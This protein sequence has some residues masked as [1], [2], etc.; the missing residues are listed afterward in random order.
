MANVMF[1]RGSQA[2]LLQYINGTKQA[3]EGSFYLTS[4]TNRL[5]IGKT[6]T[7]DN[8][9][10]AVPVNQ[11]VITVAS[12]NNLPSRTAIEAG[13]FYY[14]SG[15]NILCIY[16]GAK[17]VQINPDTNTYI[18]SRSITSSTSSITEN[19]TTYEFA[20]V[21]DIIEDVIESGG[22]TQDNNK[23]TSKFAVDGRNGVNVSVSTF[24]DGTKTYPRLV[25]SQAEQVFTATAAGDGINATIKLSD[26]NKDTEF[27]L[28]GS[29]NVLISAGSSAN[30]IKI[31]AINSTMDSASGA[32]VTNAFDANGGFTTT[33]KDS[34]GQS[35]K[36][37]AITPKISYGPQEDGTTSASA[38]FKNGNAV[39]D[40]YTKGQIDSKLRGVN[41]MVYRGT[42]G[43]GGTVTIL[44]T[45]NVSIGDT[46]KVVSNNTIAHASA[47]EGFCRVGDVL[48]ATSKSNKEGA[49]G[50]I[51]SSDLVWDY[52][53][54]GDDSQIDTQYFT[55]AITNGSLLMQDDGSNGISK[56]GFSLETTDS[57]DA[58]STVTYLD[59]E[60]DSSIAANAKNV[61]NK[62]VIKHKEQAG[63]TA[64][65]TTHANALDATQTY[66]PDETEYFEIEVPVLGYD[67]AGHITSV[68]S[69]TY[70]LLDTHQTYELQYLKSTTAT[71]TYSD[72]NAAKKGT[73]DAK[74]TIEVALKDMNSGD[75]VKK[76][77]MVTSE[78][79]FLSSNGTNLS[80]DIEWGTF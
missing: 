23:F 78:T 40:V 44:P 2:D 71:S 6:D 48:I 77:F 16:N 54:S 57:S 30:K 69:K 75:T 3:V 68:N 46:Y 11:G 50:Y 41:A 32:S 70:K 47:Y 61:Q 62:I 27:G 36:S 79:L 63:I 17:W 18:D 42:V 80:I 10:K 20:V 39:L 15:E 53:P 60:N 51:T 45:S 66:D 26:G 21:T 25:I 7:T 67:K 19:G 35:A 13:Q 9:V 5:Y 24:T 38:T 12:L 33:V 29:D 37:T 14:V 59:I 74:G 34:D 56:G 31:E 1:K 58:A 76:N 55:K 72:D 65:G 8:K 64:A 22:T 28:E 52:I 43:T 4:D 73:L 49:D